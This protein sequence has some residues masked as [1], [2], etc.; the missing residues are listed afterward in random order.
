MK[1]QPIF[2]TAARKDLKRI[3]KSALNRIEAIIQNEILRI[4]HSG[5]NLEGVESVKV[6]KVK[7]KGI[8]YRLAY[9]IIEDQGL[10]QFILI[11]TRENF[12]KQLEKRI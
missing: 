8:D 9:W 7:I 2:S 12:Y 5:N 11:K 6:W 4:P 3:D 1:Y 10:I